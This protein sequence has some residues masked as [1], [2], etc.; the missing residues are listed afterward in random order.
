MKEHG[1]KVRRGGED[2]R[3]RQDEG[4]YSFMTMCDYVID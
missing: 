3:D 2:K 4:I 1:K